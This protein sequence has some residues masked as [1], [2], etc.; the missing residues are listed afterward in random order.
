VVEVALAIQF[1]E[2]RLDTLDVAA[3]G[4]LVKDDLPERAEQPSR[5]PMEERFD[6]PPQASFR[7][8]LLAGPPLPR[9]WFLSQDGSRLLQVQHDLVAY[10]WR[11]TDEGDDYPRYSSL[12]E[13][14]ARYLQNVEK[15]LADQGKPPMRPNWCEV[16]YVNHITPPDKVAPR[17]PLDEVVVMVNS[18]RKAAFLPTPED[19][20]FGVRFR[21]G[22]AERPAGRL[23]VN[24]APGI[25]AT[26]GRPVWSLNLTAKTLA[27]EPTVDG[28]FAALDL[29]HEWA[30][31]GFRD[32]TTEKMHAQWGLR[33][34]PK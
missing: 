29:G 34:E 32:L 31:K 6:E 11:R 30:V 5:P 18:L 2:T 15:V 28:A 22:E 27:T 19:A 24:A 9:F 17:P 3:L 25:L 14:L 10:N 23:T 12:R 4:A 1:A 7:F 21:I 13:A 33:E 16:T 8:E 26:E 20:Q